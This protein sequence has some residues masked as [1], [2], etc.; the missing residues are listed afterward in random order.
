LPEKARTAIGAY[1]S[2]NR[3]GASE[4]ITAGAPIGTTATFGSQPLTVRV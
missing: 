4:S 1:L 2:S 3:S